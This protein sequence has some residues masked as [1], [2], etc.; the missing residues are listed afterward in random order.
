MLNFGWALV[1]LLLIIAAMVLGKAFFAGTPIAKRPN[2]SGNDGFPSGHAALATGVAV[3][4]F[5]MG[6]SWEIVVVL[7]AIAAIVSWQRVASGAHD[8]T[9]VIAGNILGVGIPLGIWMATR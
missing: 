8:E 4:A 6:V 1:S 9:Q 5:L 3:I 2:K 7:A